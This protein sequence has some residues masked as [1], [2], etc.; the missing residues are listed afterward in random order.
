MKLWVLIVTII[1]SSNIYAGSFAKSTERA[2]IQGGVEGASEAKFVIIVGKYKTLNSLKK[3]KANLY[4]SANIEC[5]KLAKD[6]SNRKWSYYKKSEVYNYAFNFCIR[7][8][9]SEIKRLVR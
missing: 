4:K 8:V 6:F 7:Y 9:T 1:L 5:K 2:M 3:H